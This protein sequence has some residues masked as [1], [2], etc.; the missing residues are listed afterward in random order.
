M[1]TR[2]KILY[3][4]YEGM[5]DS[6]GQ[7]Q[8]LSY[9]LK[10]SATYAITIVSCEKKDSYEKLN[11]EISEKCKAVGI[12]WQPL[13]YT[14]RP[15]VFSTL[16]DVMKMKK[17]AVSLHKENQFDIVHCRSY[18]TSI[19]GLQLKR[20]Y[21]LRFIFD[22]RGFWIDERVEAGYWNQKNILYRTVTN[23]FR[24]K[25]QQ[26]YKESD[27]IVTLTDASRKA[28]E[29]IC[30]NVAG[31]AEKIHIIPTC[32]NLEIFKPFSLIIRNEV[33]QKMAIPEN[34]FVLL[35]S[36]G[37]GANYNIS[38]LLEVYNTIKENIPEA[39][40]L[41]LSKDGV[42]GL[43]QKKNAG[44]I[45]SISLPY[46]QVGD[47]LMAGDLGVVNYT[48]HFSV[49]G[50]SPTKLAEYWACGLPAVAPEGVGDVDFLFSTYPQSGILYNKETFIDG[51]SKV[52]QVEKK[53][54]RSYADDYFSLEKGVRLYSAIYEKLK[55]D[56]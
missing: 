5:T 12:N 31:V 50:R 24:K 3:L 41:V 23:Y 29:K 27:C 45:F 11:K 53:T 6:L 2:K 15:P 37:F 28:I 32:V 4:S 47:Y 56:E 8:V 38:F 33:R 54:L 49:A 18:I 13:F 55:N 46:S 26:F 30:E 35:Y 9:M 25:E 34:A 52:Q 20:K 39:C 36:G 14:K 48:N 43:E 40:I 1:K 44:K 17:R 19:V 51:L 21:G 42:T 16:Y 22:M 7:S 10:L